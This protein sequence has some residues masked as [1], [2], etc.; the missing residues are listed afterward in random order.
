MHRAKTPRLF[1]GG[2]L[3]VR[4]LVVALGLAGAAGPAQSQNEIE[5]LD[6]L[7]EQLRQSRERQQQ[8]GAEAERLIQELEELRTG[9]ITAAAEVLRL[10]GKATVIEARVAGLR[11]EEAVKA[12]TVQGQSQ[13]LATVLASLARI[14]RQPPETLVAGPGVAI[15]VV[16]SSILLASVVP[17]LAARADT[18]N[19]ELRAV[20]SLR[21]E[22]TQQQLELVLATDQLE[23]QRETLAQMLE[24]NV[25]QKQR[26][27][28]ERDAE[29]QRM[30]NLA[31]Q[32]GDLRE[33]IRRLNAEQNAGLELP[34]VVSRS[35][36][37]ARGQVPLPVEGQ[38]IL[39]F[40]A[41]DEFG[42]PA[43]G[44][45]VESRQNAQVVAPYDGRIVFA[46]PFRSYGQLLIIAHGEGYHTLVAGLSRID[47]RVG[48]WLLSGEPVGVAGGGETGKSRIYVELRRDGEPINPAPWFA[49]RQGAR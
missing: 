17:S 9:M 2:R 5:R 4:I 41:L 38:V 14:S 25:T 12:A 18:L 43:R 24:R 16:R 10:E 13:E 33:L 6:R 26:T 39:R 48:Q 29:R 3:G 32:A 15:N 31:A 28:G 8:L 19:A 35:F 30:E 1:G 7:E 40:G 21:D 44:I 49:D 27:D 47:S 46:G 36:T 11:A 23:K 42:A 37:Q 20:R 45:T 22:I 34:P